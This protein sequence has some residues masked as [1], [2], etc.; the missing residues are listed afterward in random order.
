MKYSRDKQ[1][2]KL[3]LLVFI[4][5][6]VYLAL[7]H[8]DIGKAISFTIGQDQAVWKSLFP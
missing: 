1:G 4:A 5:L 7:F 6:F 3:I 2:N 8:F